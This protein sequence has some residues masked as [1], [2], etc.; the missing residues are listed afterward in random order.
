MAPSRLMV[1]FIYVY[2][3]INTIAAT[4]AV[5]RYV[6]KHKFKLDIF[7]SPVNDEHCT[8]DTGTVNKKKSPSFSRL[9]VIIHYS[10]DL[11][12]I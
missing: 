4:N 1:R 10:L 8:T 12:N 11:K 3:L 9:Y 6:Q 7:F 5:F 2:I